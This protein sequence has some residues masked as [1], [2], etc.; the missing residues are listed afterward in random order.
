MRSLLKHLALTLWQD[1]ILR[2]RWDLFWEDWEA[3]RALE[4]R[5]VCDYSPF[6][7]GEKVLGPFPSY[8]KARRAAVRHIRRNPFGAAAVEYREGTE[9]TA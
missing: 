4:W 8:W 7:P 5:V 9:G 1:A 6:R 2:G 3:F